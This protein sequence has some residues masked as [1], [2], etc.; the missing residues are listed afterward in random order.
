MGRKKS[1]PIQRPQS[2]VGGES[3]TNEE[4]QQ[5]E[6]EEDGTAVHT[7]A[8]NYNNNY[9]TSGEVLGR[10]TTTVSVEALLAAEVREEQQG[11]LVPADD[12][13]ENGVGRK[14]K[15]KSLRFA[16][17][18][19][20]HTDEQRNG[21]QTAAVTLKD[22]LDQ[23]L[24]EQEDKREKRKAS[25]TI[26]RKRQSPQ[27]QKQSQTKLVATT[28]ADEEE[29][30]SPSLSSSLPEI[31]IIPAQQSQEEEASNISSSV[32][33]LIRIRTTIDDH[34]SSSS[35]TFLLETTTKATK[36]HQIV[37][38]SWTLSSSTIMEVVTLNNKQP[39]TAVRLKTSHGV[40]TI[41]QYCVLNCG[42]GGCGGVPVN[43]LLP[44]VGGASGKSS[45][46][47]REMWDD[48]AR[49]VQQGTLYCRLDFSGFSRGSNE[50]SS[51]T[52]RVSIGIE[53]S[54]TLTAGD[55]ATVVVQPKGKKQQRQATTILSRAL[56]ILLPQSLIADVVNHPISSGRQSTMDSSD[57]SV[58]AKHVYALVDNQQYEK[59]DQQDDDD[60]PRSIPGLVP[61]LRPYQQAAVQWMLEREQLSAQRSNSTSYEWELAWIVLYSTGTE[62]NQCQWEPLHSSRWSGQRAK[63]K[64]DND[65]H[66]PITVLFHSPFTGWW[67]DSY[68]KAR[69]ATIGR[70]ILLQNEEEEP[71][72]SSIRGGILAESM[73]LGKT[74]E[75]LACI[76]ANPRQPFDSMDSSD[77]ESSSTF[78]MS[79]QILASCD[80]DTTPSG[81]DTARTSSTTSSEEDSDTSTKHKSR[82]VA[83]VARSERDN[84][85]S[86]DS[87][88][89][90]EFEFDG[91]DHSVVSATENPSPSSSITGQMESCLIRTEDLECATQ[92]LGVCI[93]GQSIYLT[94][95]LPVVLCETCH[96]PM[97][98]VCADYQ[99]APPAE[100][101]VKQTREELIRFRYGIKNID[102]RICP[103]MNCP[104][105]CSRNEAK[106]QSRATLIVTPPAIL[107]QWQREIQR[108]TAIPTTN[109]SRPL[110]VAIYPGVKTLCNQQGKKALQDYS[111]LI[112]PRRLG[113]ADVV[114]MTFDALMGDLNHSDD[115]PFVESGGRGGRALRQRKIYRV[116]PSPLLS[117]NWWRICLDE[118]QRVET[119]TA[120][121]AK[122]ALKLYA[123][124][125][126]CVS[127]TPVGRGK[128]EDLHG[129][130]LF[131]RLLPFDNKAWFAGCFRKQHRGFEDRIR[132]L[133]HSSFWRSTKMSERVREQM[134]I[135]E[136]I[137][138]KVVL[139]FSSVERHF[140]QRQHEETLNAAADLQS[141][142]KAGKK[143]SLSLMSNLSTQIH[144]LRAAC[145]HPQVGSSGLGRGLKRRRGTAGL[146]SEEEDPY[147]NSR[148]LTMD[149]ILDRLIDDARL[150]AEEAQRLCLLHN[151]AMG[152]L[153]KLKVQAKNR[154]ITF[155][156]SDG[157]LLTES[158]KIY[159]ESL[160]TIDENSRPTQ[161]TGEA[162]LG[163]STGFQF[164]HKIIRD[165]R[166]DLRWKVT[167]YEEEKAQP[168]EIWA[169][170]DF[171]G[172]SKKITQIR[173]RRLKN[174]SPDKMDSRN[175]DCAEL[176]ELHPRTC[177]F[178]VSSTS[179]G[180]AF[181][182]V[183][184]FELPCPT[185]EVDSEWTIYGN[186]RTN[187]SKSWRL[188]IQDYHHSGLERLSESWCCAVEIELEEAYIGGDSLQRLHALHNAA[189][190]FE[191]LIKIHHEEKDDKNLQCF[192]SAEMEEKAKDMRTEARRIENLYMEGI[193]PIHRESQRL[194]KMAVHDQQSAEQKLFESSQSTKTKSGQKDC[195]DDGWWNDILLLTSQYGSPHEQFELCRRVHED[196]NSAMEGAFDRRQL[197]Q[198]PFPPF[199][200][201]I[202]LYH[203]VNIRMQDLREV[204]TPGSISKCLDKFLKFP[205]NP[206][207]GS[208]FESS[209]CERC[210]KDWTWTGP[211]CGHCKLSI[212]L[213]KLEPDRLLQ[214]VLGSVCSWMKGARASGQLASARLE[215]HVDQRA[216]LFFD[217]LEGTKK[218]KSAAEKAWRV[219]LDLLNDLDEL[220]MCKGAMRLSIEGED[221]SKSTE[222]ELNGIVHPIDVASSFLDH[223]VKQATTFANLRRHNNTL[224]YL[225]NQ[226]KERMAD[227]ESSS[228]NKDR[229]EDN[230]IL[231][232]SDFEGQRAV[233]ACGHSFHYT[234]C[235]EQL[236]ARSSSSHFISCPLRCTIQTK[237]DKVMVATDKRAED[238]VVANRRVKGSWG[239]KVTRLVADVLDVSDRGE[240]SIVFSQWEDMM[241]VV[242]SAFRFNNI[243]FVRVASLAKIAD[244]TKRFRSQDC[245]VLLLNVKNGAEGLTLV[246][247]S[248]IFM[249]EPLLNCGLDL[250]GKPSLKLLVTLCIFALFV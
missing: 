134:G 15:T 172:P 176:V 248:H 76:L 226:S 64:D 215:S 189:L 235:L 87:S 19:H 181:V 24:Q 78:Q 173:L 49:A 5:E 69:Q 31:E 230:C 219:H 14:K 70:E 57:A 124:H 188:Y 39:M 108:H 104:C 135:P 120:A 84:T 121:S 180:G 139:E 59:V 17:P 126:W 30:S 101:A 177:I 122:M 199:N 82:T 220:N 118:A 194:L 237:R 117:I 8:N 238:S 77:K 37:L 88:S 85:K 208:I 231:C 160:E 89:N 1:T 149:Q 43:Q 217:A 140:Y 66:H 209:T 144:K 223:Q 153:A 94:E 99:P 212:G 106:V 169:K 210:K 157:R 79:S 25:A 234:P 111:S 81:K 137:E 113:D 245:T 207:E 151:N 114:L 185:N 201:V 247:A 58:T 20:P 22:R 129:L 168:R 42:G 243:S 239:T 221:L 27:K 48:V 228:M 102:C 116:V 211:M 73:G 10:V 32:S 170:F 241:D 91:D 3:S 141:R 50:P 80:Q 109:G 23:I 115:N 250:Q 203:G 162:V 132:H 182:D 18:P 71:D 40:R 205:T 123:E 65:E 54:T 242:E 36:S 92:A 202:G 164:P 53:P 131:Q 52:V 83:G 29:D 183:V 206:N 105:C 103:E 56:T 86:G 159:L 96:E 229:D 152:A 138:K 154:G 236:I 41:L 214:I 61:T 142:E 9:N 200:D 7:T 62:E 145:C 13:E 204:I 146:S 46:D 150:K 68:E 218:A 246:E 179:V 174:E 60:P 147:G 130:L 6:E 16:I 196:I 75:V 11:I 2:S 55:P 110:K 128:L 225:K 35:N 112:H 51:S 197:A 165:G 178:Q 125:R 74:V 93:C 232:L 156:Q 34:A 26:K 47:D 224:R 63:L 97:H 163:G 227:A 107:S 98:A 95:K 233:L 4:Q 249:V 100:T 192:S 184:K 143:R 127:G 155:Q 45:N 148:I 240:K 166:A 90:E 167:S 213:N 216:K 186:F 119:P 187:R 44:P 21:R 175:E 161:V 244:C 67:V 33:T 190:S 72:D 171:E 133:L 191:S 38:A 222:A 198:K 195:W 158:C 12:E 136:Q 193:V 28:T